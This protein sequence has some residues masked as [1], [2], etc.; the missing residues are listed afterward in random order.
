MP[1]LS[2]PHVFSGLDYLAS[3][4]LLLDA[5]YATCYANSATENLLA[6]SGRNLIGRPLDQVMHY[7]FTLGQ[8]LENAAINDWSYTGQSVEVRRV[9]GEILHLNCTVTPLHCAEAPEIRLLVELF[10]IDQQL[11]ASREAWLIEQQEA[12]RELIRNLAHEIKNPLGGIRGAAQLLERE[13]AQPEY[14]EYTQIIIQEADRLQN[15]M[16]RLLSPHR[17]M[18]Q[19]GSVNIH[20]VL[21]RVRS[22][23]LLEFPVTL[24]IRQDYDTSLP[25]LAGDREQLIQVFLNIARNAAQAL[26]GEGEIIL[27]TRVARQV[28][29]AQRRVRLA[30]EISVID[31]GPGIPEAL[32]G[33]IFFPLVSGRPGGSGLGLTLAQSFVQQHQGCIECESRPG[34]TCFRVR[35]PLEAA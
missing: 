29:L 26:S 5:R 11:K 20:D 35:L 28:T 15:L 32:Q 18:M 25:E 34:H 8:A 22:L 24:T 1:A 33:R 9:D 4:V 19:I 14:R 6:V 27:Q 30:L 10:P 12:S 13:L 17:M 31:S 21:E 23:L 3:A 7:S 2:L 16:Q